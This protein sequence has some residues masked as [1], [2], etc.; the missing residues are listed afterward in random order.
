M[1]ALERVSS[2]DSCA[3][4]SP[5]GDRAGDLKMLDARL[6]DIGGY[7]CDRLICAGSPSEV[8]CVQIEV[9]Y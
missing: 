8:E 5:E 1:K 7:L 2:R 6:K 4:G 3:K 9:S